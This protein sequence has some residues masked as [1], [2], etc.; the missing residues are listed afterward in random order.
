MHIH[1]IKGDITVAKKLGV[2]VKAIIEQTCPLGAKFKASSV[3]S[4]MA[5]LPE[6]Q[7]DKYFGNYEFEYWKTKYNDSTRGLL[8]KTNG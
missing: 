8:L 2:A 3:F 7:Y 5:A 4:N 1:T 6:L